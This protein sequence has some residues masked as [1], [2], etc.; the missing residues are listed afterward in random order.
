MGTVA[1]VVAT[2]LSGFL[3][4]LAFPTT[5]LH[6]LAWVALV[7]W[8]VALRAGSSAR[9]VLLGWL[10]A[11][12]AS[13]GLNDW[14]PRAVSTYYLQPAWVGA[15]FFVGVASFTAAP[16]FVAFA[17]VWRRLTRR[18]TAATPLLAAAAWVAAELFRTRVL[19]D[20]WALLGYSQVPVPLFLQV[21]DATGVYGT[22][23]V[24]A[25][26]NAALALAGLGA[27]QRPAARRGLAVTAALVALVAAYGALR[28]RTYD[29]PPAPATE[30]A[31]VQ[32]NL[33]L[34]SQW[35]P[36]FYGMNLDAYLGL[37]RDALGRAPAPRL[38]VWPESALSFFLDDEAGFRAAIAS[39]LA[40]RAAELVTGG[41]R[42]ANGGDPPYHNTAFLLGPDGVIDGWYDKRRLLPFAEYFP[43]GSIE[44]LQRQFGRVR[45]F[46]PGAPTAPL[47][48]MAGPGG[49][50][51]CNEAFFDEPARERVHEG[52]GLLLALANDSWVGESKYAEQAT[53]WT[54]VRAIEQRRWLVRASTSGPSAVIAPSGRFTAR[55]GAGMR[56]V[57][58]GAVGSRTEVT[59][60]A[61]L[62]DAFA[63]AC[64]LVTLAVYARRART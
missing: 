20:P 7:P 38:V 47:P 25:A 41:V 54:A 62:G 32:P 42:T 14:F 37:T 50:I 2:G 15:A 11:V 22:S 55:S 1:A 24:L 8:L 46:T 9:A 64:V 48:T 56:S 23:F 60:Y 26:A 27:A 49:V 4:A 29:A 63:L 10:W 12:V 58:T 35:R 34:G 28:L 16:A 13:Y 39:V 5:A 18:P 53:A 31:I 21:A 17:F 43:L 3:Y 51:V 45:E 52:A 57:V 59:A 40:P 30:V 61:R 19:G 44:L 6:P 33:D 36:E